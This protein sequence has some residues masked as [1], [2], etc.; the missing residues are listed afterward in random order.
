MACYFLECVGETGGA[1]LV[2]DNGDAF[3]EVGYS[4]YV[5][6]YGDVDG[7]SGSTE[8]GLFL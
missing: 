1:A 3:H 5:A 4:D 7:S 8:A 2:L 6:C